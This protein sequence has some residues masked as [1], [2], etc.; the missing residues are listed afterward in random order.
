MECE[1]GSLLLESL[2]RCEIC[3][4]DCD[5]CREPKNRFKCTKCTDPLKFLN[6]IN[7]D[8]GYCTEAISCIDNYGFFKITINFWY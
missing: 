2:H 5:Y 8:F 1:D 6:I 3:H 4:A 7:L